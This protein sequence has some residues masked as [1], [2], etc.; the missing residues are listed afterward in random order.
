MHICTYLIAR[1]GV[2]DRL[3]AHLRAVGVGAAAPAAA[4]GSWV[5]RAKERK[6]YAKA[7]A[8]DSRCSYERVSLSVVVVKQEDCD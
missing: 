6:D 3:E 2:A 8:P 4:A 7:T 1:D 5:R